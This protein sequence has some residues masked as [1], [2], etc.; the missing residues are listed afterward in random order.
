MEEREEKKM[1]EDFFV[2]EDTEAKRLRLRERAT[3]VA[4]F[5]YCSLLMSFILF[6]FITHSLVKGNGEK[7]EKRCCMPWRCVQPYSLDHGNCMKKLVIR[8]KSGDFLEILGLIWINHN[9]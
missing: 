6:Y 8:G 2:S 5:Y 7:E 4:T 3:T 9:Q 1:V